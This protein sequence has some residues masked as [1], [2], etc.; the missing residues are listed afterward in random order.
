[1]ESNV[2]R[3]ERGFRDKTCPLERDTQPSGSL[4][5]K[6]VEEKSHV[7]G[8]CFLSTHLLPVAIDLPLLFRRQ[9]QH[10]RPVGWSQIQFFL[11]SKQ[12]NKQKI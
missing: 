3:G 1:V 6:W 11:Q 9:S 10:R 5:E 8:V 7:V 2:G 4:G 12:R